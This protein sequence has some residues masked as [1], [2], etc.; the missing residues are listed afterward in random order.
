METDAPT[1]PLPVPAESVAANLGS[2]LTVAPRR[3]ATLR[4]DLP[5]DLTDL[6]AEPVLVRALPPRG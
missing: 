2:R 1:R 5:A 6:L 3:W 4:P